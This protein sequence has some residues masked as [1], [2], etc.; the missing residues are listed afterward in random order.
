MAGSDDDIFGAPPKKTLAHEIGQT[1][2]ALSAEELAARIELLKTEIA[3][4]E[5]AI[6]ARQTTKEA[7]SAFFKR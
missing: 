3:R 7:A 4:L 6:K 1:I 5:T 2:D